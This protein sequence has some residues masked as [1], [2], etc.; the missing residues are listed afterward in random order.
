[1]LTMAGFCLL[2]VSFF[3]HYPVPYDVGLR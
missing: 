2:L 3:S 1:M